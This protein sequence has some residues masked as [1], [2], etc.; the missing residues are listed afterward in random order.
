[1]VVTPTPLVVTV[2]VTVE[3]T[4]EVDVGSVIRVMNIE[5]LVDVVVSSWT[6][7]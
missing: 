2:V 5:V 6:V 1:M 4:V 7:C 3:S